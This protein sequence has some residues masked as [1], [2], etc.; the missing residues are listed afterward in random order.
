MKKDKI[1]IDYCKETGITTAIYNTDLGRF[2]GT[3]QYN[4][5]EEK[6]PS[7]FYVGN[8]LAEARAR[9]AYLNAKSA[10]KKAQL[11]GLE[12]LKHS[13]DYDITVWKYANQM[14]KAINQELAEIKENKELEL[15]TIKNVLN[16][17]KTYIRAR[18]VSPE[19]RKDYQE[20]IA[21]GLK[22]LGQKEE[23][24]KS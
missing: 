24:S 17:R 10:N 1:H 13:C 14:E 3:A 8:N 4:M 5:E 23:K 11:K 18:S 6:F 16:S 19:E 21:L 15:Q 12:R 20:R 22:M 7:S 9:I 2:T